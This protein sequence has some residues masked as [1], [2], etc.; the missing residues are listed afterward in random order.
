MTKTNIVISA[1]RLF[2]QRGYRYVSLVDIAREVGITKGGIYH[3]FS[4][5]EE[6]LNASVQCLFDHVTEKVF[7]VFDADKSV[8]EMLDELIVDQAVERYVDAVF[9]MQGVL[10]PSSHANFML[11]VMSRFPQIHERIARDMAQFC[12]AL[13]TKLQKA[14]NNGEIR[15]DVDANVLAALL[16]PVV[17]G[18]KI[19]G[20]LYQDEPS[21]RKIVATIWTLIANN[22]GK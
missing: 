9:G 4:S 22:P 19:I 21:R 8:H 14:M 13:R 12:G 11:E 5:K 16:F 2:L 10:S 20:E 6:L 7:A 1:T 18:P 3:Y 17:Q 15:A